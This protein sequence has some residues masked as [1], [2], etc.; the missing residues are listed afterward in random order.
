[1]GNVFNPQKSSANFDAN[2]SR[3]VGELDHPIVD[4]FAKA[5]YSSLNEKATL[6]GPDS[7]V[8]RGM[9][10]TMPDGMASNNNLYDD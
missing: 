8:G 9:A 5:S 1:M 3:R 6:F 7:I 10:L 2:T 4:D